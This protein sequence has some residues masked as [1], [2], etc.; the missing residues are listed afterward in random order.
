MIGARLLLYTKAYEKINMD[1]TIKIGCYARWKSEESRMIIAGQRR[2]IKFTGN[3]EQAQQLDQLIQEE[4]NQGLI[5][6]FNQQEVLLWNRTFAIKKPG[7]GLRRIMDCRPLNTQLKV[8][9]FTMNDLNKVLEIWKKNDWAQVPCVF[10]QR[11]TLY[12]SGNGLRDLNSTEDFRKDNINNKRQSE[13]QESSSDSELCRRHSV[14][15]VGSALARGR[16]KMDS[17]GIQE[18]WM[19][20]QRE[21][22]H[23]VAGLAICVPG[24]EVQF[25]NNGD[26]VDQ[27][28]K[29]GIGNVSPKIDKT[30]NGIKATKDKKRGKFGWQASI[31]HPIIQTRRTTSIANKQVNE[32]SSENVG[33]DER[34]DSNEKV[35]DSVVLVDKP[36]GEQQTKD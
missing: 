14:P 3:E 19:G 8:Q 36:C 18:I 27:Q 5:R 34:N 10:A 17:V 23:I 20:D 29:E 35:L 32:Q 2:I 24:M 9:H 21:Q 7:G 4:L 25:S 11:N 16:D 28:E 12:A 33:L 15:D 1:K 31:F 26:L 6:V 22:E 30:N 13:K